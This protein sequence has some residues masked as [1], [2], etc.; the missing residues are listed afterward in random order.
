MSDESST[1][2]N[3][4]MIS[5]GSH[6]LFVSVTGLPHTNGD[7]PIVF[8]PGNGDVATSF[9]AVERAIKCFATVVLYDRTGLGRSEDAPTPTNPTAV[10]SAI[11]LHTLL[12]NAGLTSP[13]ILAAHS[14]GGI[15][16]REF[17][18]LYPDHV[19]GMVLI[20][21]ASERNRHLFET[22]NL[23]LLAV[24]GGLDYARV[25][26]LR[27]RS[28]LTRDEWRTRA[29]GMARGLKTG[30]A[31]ATGGIPICKT[32]EEKK[33]YLTRPLGS[34]P[35]SV[36]GCNSTGDYR[37]L[38]DKAVEAGNGTEEQREA[39]RQLL[40]VWVEHEREWQEEQVQLSSN[41][42]FVHLPD[43]GHH[44][45]ILRPDVVAEEIRWV[46]EQVLKRAGKL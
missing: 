6:S 31:E 16:A 11:E 3:D 8:I 38:F 15:I 18:H 41:A 22:P 46:R 33:Q 10:S 13:V 30:Q 12:S 17:L 44:V 29:I 4:S 1:P 34:K 25:T 32:L 39:Y 45:Q 9:A 19:A 37:K 26:G 40:E 24:F 35:L 21:A 36:V 20:D 2:Q 7:P 43:C 42:R 14:Y 5:I 27:D 28:K 23:D